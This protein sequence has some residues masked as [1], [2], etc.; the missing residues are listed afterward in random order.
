MLLPCML[1]R[2]PACWTSSDAATGMDAC[3]AHQMRNAWTSSNFGAGHV[4]NHHQPLRA[5]HRFLFARRTECNGSDRVVWDSARRKSLLWRTVAQ[6]LAWHTA[7]RAIPTGCRELQFRHRT[8]FPADP[9][10]GCA[11]RTCRVHLLHSTS[12]G[13]FTWRHMGSVSRHRQSWRPPR[14]SLGRCLG[15]GPGPPFVAITG[16]V[17][18][19]RRI[20]P[21]ALLRM[22]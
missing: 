22:I 13:A 20:S 15:L 12:A 3:A 9:E 8:R 16:L 6:G 11:R 10:C 14:G 2:E 5:S 18:R 7:D 1:E 19:S 17:Q 4:G 21:N